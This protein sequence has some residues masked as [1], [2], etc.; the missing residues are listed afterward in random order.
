MHQLNGSP[1]NSVKK[2][3]KDEAQLA[4]VR[5]QA[6]LNGTGYSFETPAME[7]ALLRA[8]LGED[9][10]IAGRYNVYCD[11]TPEVTAV[12]V[13]DATGVSEHKYLNV[14]CGNRLY[15]VAAPEAW[16]GEHREI[17]ERVAAVA[18]GP[19]F[20][21]GGGRLKILPDGALLVGGYSSRYGRG[22][23][24]RAKAA[25][26]RAVANARS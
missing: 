11:I 6:N 26:C 19:V 24:D 10:R 7:E 13:H 17:L 12:L 5:L 14:K 2:T 16:T 1:E 9:V 21:D 20:P 4:V 22:D 18:E 15:I 8:L 23:H 3:E 25:F